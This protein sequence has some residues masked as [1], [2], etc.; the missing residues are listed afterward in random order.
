MKYNIGDELYLAK[1]D[2]IE[3]G[4]IGYFVLDHF[5]SKETI[6]GI[7]TY[8]DYLGGVYISY[9][10]SN[11]QRFSVHENPE[12]LGFFSDKDKAEEFAKKQAIMLGRQKIREYESDIREK[13]QRIK[14][15]EQ[16]IKEI[17]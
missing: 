4:E 13:Q 15:L 8:K 6:I 11:D 9:H 14:E 7:E 1:Y 17:Q 5:V 3:K 10:L 16:S 2:L 12:K